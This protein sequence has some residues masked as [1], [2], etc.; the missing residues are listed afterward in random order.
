MKNSSATAGDT[1][2]PGLIP[3][4]GR[5][6]G[7]GHGNPLHYSCLENPHGQKSL[8]VIVHR[9][10]KSQTGLKQLST[11]GHTC[12]YSRR[13]KIQIN[14]KDKMNII[15]PSEI[16]TNVCVCKYASVFVYFD[17]K[18]THTYTLV[19]FSF[20]YFKKTQNHYCT[21]FIALFKVT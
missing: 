10:K 8:M 11:H 5:S 16:T 2:D 14:R 20:I 9:V 18:Y 1:R 21:Y 6:P 19:Y 3:G 4:Y 15:L 7:G 13:S 12:F 17:F